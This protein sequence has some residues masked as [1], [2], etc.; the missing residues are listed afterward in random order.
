[1]SEPDTQTTASGSEDGGFIK[2]IYKD[3]TVDNTF[4][5]VTLTKNL[6]VK[7]LLVSFKL[8]DGYAL[9]VVDADG[10]AVED[11]DTA[12][13]DAMKLLVTKGGETVKTYTIS[14]NAGGGA[15]ESSAVPA[16][17]KAGAPV[18]LIVGIVAAVLVLGGGVTV[19]IL[20]K[21]GRLFKKA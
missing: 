1:M 8:S 7:D 16:D 15:D 12:V 11:E 9:Q 4:G 13:T 5:A 6:K 19:L 21:K 14:L 3:V 2:S 20:W 17:G 10:A 18:G